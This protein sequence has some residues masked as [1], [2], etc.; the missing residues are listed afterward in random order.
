MK[1]ATKFAPKPI[2]EYTTGLYRLIGNTGEAKDGSII[3]I[4]GSNISGKRAFEINDISDYWNERAVLALE[5]L[6]AGSTVTLT[7]EAEDYV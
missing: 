3:M 1:F 5:P 7:V 4:I 2:S 6:P